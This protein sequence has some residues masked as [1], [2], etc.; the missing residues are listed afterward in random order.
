MFEKEDKPLYV[1]IDDKGRTMERF[2]NKNEA[3]DYVDYKY[4]LDQLDYG[5]IRIIMHHVPDSHFPTKE[6]R[7]MKKRNEALNDLLG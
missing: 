1:I 3:I 5:N 4:G 2:L 6:Q 7:I